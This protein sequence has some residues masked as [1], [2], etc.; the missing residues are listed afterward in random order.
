MDSVGQD[1]H[2]GVKGRVHVST[3]RT[4]LIQP[5]LSALK[6]GPLTHTKEKC[7]QHTII[8]RKPHSHQELSSSARAHYNIDLYVY[9]ETRDNNKKAMSVEE[10]RFVNRHD[11]WSPYKRSWQSWVPIHFNKE[12]IQLPNK[13]TGT[14]WPSQPSETYAGNQ[15]WWQTI[16]TF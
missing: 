2:E 1:V 5:Q 11:K 10:W 6:T 3:S 12:G 14:E 9:A 13:S 8:M 16:K 7:G 15:T 4:I